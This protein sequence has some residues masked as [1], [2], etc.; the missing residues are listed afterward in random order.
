FRANALLQEEMPCMQREWISALP[1]TKFRFGGSRAKPGSKHEIKLYVHRYKWFRQCAY[2]EENEPR[3]LQF[4]H[5]DPSTK[6][7]NISNATDYPL[8]AVKAEMDKCELICAN[9]HFKLHAN[10]L[11]RD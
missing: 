9:C 2:C 1:K 7:F 5:I 6:S 3:A 10:R 11:D 8:A 4:H